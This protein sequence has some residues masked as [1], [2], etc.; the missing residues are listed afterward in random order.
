MFWNRKIV[1]WEN[2]RLPLVQIV[3]ALLP[4]FE[5]LSG[6][7]LG[8]A[9]CDFTKHAWAKSPTFEVGVQNLTSSQVDFLDLAS[10]N[11]KLKPS[12]GFRI[13]PQQSGVYIVGNR[14]EER[15]RNPGWI[16]LHVTDVERKR[17]DPGKNGYEEWLWE[18]RFMID[19]KG[20][21]EEGEV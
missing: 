12:R 10:P 1:C 17:E 4:V 15:G 20:Q 19:S 11:F 18:K 7:C 14:E 16:S 21:F 3:Y 8:L 9:K 13:P 5:I 2:P 6:I